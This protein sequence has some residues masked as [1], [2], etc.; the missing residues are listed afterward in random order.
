MTTYYVGALALKEGYVRLSV[1][2]DRVLTR[3][4]RDHLP[5]EYDQLPDL[6]SVHVTLFITISKRYNV[7]AEKDVVVRGERMQIGLVGR[8]DEYD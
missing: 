5:N 4:I 3:R 1:L 6:P 7:N 8:D 2:L